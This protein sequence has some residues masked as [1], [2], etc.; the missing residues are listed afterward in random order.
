[1]AL[2]YT[3]TWN[4]IEFKYYLDKGEVKKVRRDVAL[5]KSL[6]NNLSDREKMVLKY[7][8]K[9]ALIIYENLYDCLREICDALL[10]LDEYKSY[11]HQASITYLRKYGFDEVFV[12]KLD[13]FRF[14]R[15]SS[16]YYGKKLTEEDAK[17]IR[18]F[19]LKNKGKLLNI[20]KQKIEE[21][22]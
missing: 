13:D 8:L 17:E 10:A 15:N 2:F 14:K 1:M 5:A 4:M 7:S 6:I 22:A 16:K 18:E 11:S 20:L 19:Y 21:V 3:V 12:K 9:D